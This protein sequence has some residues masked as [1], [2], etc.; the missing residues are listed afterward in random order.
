MKSGVDSHVKYYRCS[1]RWM[2]VWILMNI[3]WIEL[4]WDGSV[5]YMNFDFL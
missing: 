2:N 5:G 4:A 1:S 3:I